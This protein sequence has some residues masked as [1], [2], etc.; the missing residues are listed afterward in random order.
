MGSEAPEGADAED[1]EIRFLSD[2]RAQPDVAA[3]DFLVTLPFAADAQVAREVVLQP[4]A[5]GE[6]VVVMGTAADGRLLLDLRAIGAQ[7]AEDRQAT[8]HDRP[9]AD[10]RKVPRGHLG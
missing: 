2:T 4:E 1:V 7:A 10:R 9:R 8:R 6:V 3:A 5:E